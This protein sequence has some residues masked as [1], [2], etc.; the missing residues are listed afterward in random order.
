MILTRAI[1]IGACSTTTDRFYSYRRCAFI[2]KSR[3][4]ERDEQVVSNGSRG[5]HLKCMGQ[6]AR[7]SVGTDDVPCW[8]SSTTRHSQVIDN[9]GSARYYATRGV[10]S[11][12]LRTT[13]DERRSDPLSLSFRPS[14]PKWLA[15]VAK[16]RVLV[17][18][19][20][21]MANT[22]HISDW[23]DLVRRTAAD[24]ICIRCHVAP[25]RCTRLCKYLTTS[26]D[27]QR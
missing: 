17:R 9:R 15:R 21:L 7:V 12:M 1:R 10:I 2:Q 3:V 20:A 23:F 8:C 22:R 18:S 11:N 25:N 6:H 13:S 5:I 24:G 14:M 27:G 16:R 4:K 19:V 26:D